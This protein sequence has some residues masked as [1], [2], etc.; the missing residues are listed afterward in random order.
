MTRDHDGIHLVPGGPELPDA[1]ALDAPPAPAAPPLSQHPTAALI[2]RLGIGIV[3]PYDFALD[4][5][6]WRWVPDHV[7]LHLTRTPYEDLPVSLEQARLIGVPSMVADRAHDLVEI[8]PDA[9]VYACTAGSFVRGQLG[10]AEIVE[11]LLGTGIPAAVTTSGALLAALE[12][13][14]IHSLSVATPYD[15]EIGDALRHFLDSAG[16]Q[17]NGSHNLGLHRQIWTVPYGVTADLVRRCVRPG[18]EAV[19]VSC[20]NLPTYDVIAPLEAE[21]GIPVLTANQVTMWAALRALATS[22][23]GPDQRLITEGVS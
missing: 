2:G 4:R 8:Q 3:A 1:L 17:V 5:E 7:T 16:V 22:A 6:L 14:D 11:A 12:A 23:V 9:I 10:Q 18:D 15:D 21:L 13:L 19:F 20:T